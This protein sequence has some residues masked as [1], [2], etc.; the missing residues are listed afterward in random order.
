MLSG[1]IAPKNAHYYY[2][3]YS[4]QRESSVFVDSHA[5][6]SNEAE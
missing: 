3:M 5:V 4:Y 6:E 2:Y 1:E